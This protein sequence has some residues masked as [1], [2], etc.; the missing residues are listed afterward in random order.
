M[1]RISDVEKDVGEMFFANAPCIIF[2]TGIIIA[3]IV[4]AVTAVMTLLLLSIQIEISRDY[5]RF[6]KYYFQY[7]EIQVEGSL[8]L[9]ILDRLT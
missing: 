4:I 2:A 3:Y 7:E 8:S 1:F 6:K 5:K 9:V